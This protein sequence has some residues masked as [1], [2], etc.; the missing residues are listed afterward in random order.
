[1]NFLLTRFKEDFFLGS[2]E[3]YLCWSPPA[4]K[5]IIINITKFWSY[6][7]VCL[8]LLWTKLRISAVYSCDLVYRPVAIKPKNLWMIFTFQK[9]KEVRCSLIHTSGHAD[10]VRLKYLVWNFRLIIFFFNSVRPKF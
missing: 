2:I 3:L 10:S 8:L 5:S 9:L 7:F 4:D 1:M 6:T